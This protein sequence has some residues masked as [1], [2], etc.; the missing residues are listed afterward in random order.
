MQVTLF[1]PGQSER[2]VMGDIFK[3]AGQGCSARPVDEALEA[4][5][6]ASQGTGRVGVSQQAFILPR[7]QASRCQ[8]RLSQLQWDWMSRAID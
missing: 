7:Q 3:D 6:Q 5:A 1:E 8:W 2:K 4:G